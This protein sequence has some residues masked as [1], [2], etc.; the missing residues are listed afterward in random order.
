MAQRVFRLLEAYTPGLKWAQKAKELGKIQHD[1][2]GKGKQRERPKKVRKS[3][4]EACKMHVPKAG[5]EISTASTVQ[6]EF[7]KSPKDRLRGLCEKEKKGKQ[8]KGGGK[9]Q[10][11]K[12][13]R[14]E[15]LQGL[16]TD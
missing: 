11:T 4:L 12:R 16:N 14:H 15:T 2:K 6:E 5:T 3:T 8:G 1:M 7:R 9:E 10:T 13:S